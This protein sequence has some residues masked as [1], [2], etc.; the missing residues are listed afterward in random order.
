MRSAARTAVVL[1]AVV[2]A[3]L[4]ARSG[5]RAQVKVA[6]TGNDVRITILS[7]VAR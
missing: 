2:P 3:V 4:G 5:A 6:D 1:A 7:N